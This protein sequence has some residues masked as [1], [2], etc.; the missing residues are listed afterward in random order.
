MNLWYRLCFL[1]HPHYHQ[2]KSACNKYPENS[3]PY[4]KVIEKIDPSDPILSKLALSTGQG[5]QRSA[6]QTGALNQCDSQL[7]RIR[8]V[9]IHHNSSIIASLMVHSSFLCLISQSLMVVTIVYMV[10]HKIL[11]L[12]FWFSC[13]VIDPAFKRKQYLSVCNFKTSEFLVGI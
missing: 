3:R 4:T 5:C 9:K 11:F 2:I 7:A 8:S 12:N 1:T 6:L 13:H 10:L